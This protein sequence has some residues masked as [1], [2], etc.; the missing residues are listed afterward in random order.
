MSN[1]VIVDIEVL[2]GTG[3]DAYSVVD[4]AIEVIQASGLKYA[5]GP[6]GTNG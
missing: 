2:P 3:A 4:R 5:V 6:M 1:T